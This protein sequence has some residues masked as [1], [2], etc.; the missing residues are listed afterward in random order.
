[1]PNVV[2]IAAGI[3]VLA[4][5]GLAAALTESP[6]PKTATVACWLCGIILILAGLTEGVTL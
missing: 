1:M 3:V 5:W 6:P 2:L 4:A